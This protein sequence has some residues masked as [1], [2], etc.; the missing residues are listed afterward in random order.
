MLA[1]LITILLYKLSDIYINGTAFQVVGSMEF[2]EHF[3]L[4]NQQNEVEVCFVCTCCLGA[5]RG[6]NVLKEVSTEW[7]KVKADTNAMEDW[8]KIAD[9]KNAASVAAEMSASDKR[10]AVL[11]VKKRMCTLVNV[12][13]NL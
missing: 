6:E 12:Y 4:L 10:R 1:V 2:I 13:S 5:D 3:L 8:K 7:A 9:N 11:A